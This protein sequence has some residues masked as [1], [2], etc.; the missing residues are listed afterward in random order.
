MRAIWS[1]RV[2][3]DTLK[4]AV[5]LYPAVTKQKLALHSIHSTCHSPIKIE[6]RCPIHGTI[7]PHETSKGYEMERREYIVLEN[8]V[9]RRLQPQ[10]R[11][12]FR[13]QHFAS[14]SSFEPIDFR[15]SYY[16]LPR[17]SQQ[18]QYGIF[19]EALRNSGLYG[20]GKIFIKRSERMAVIW[21]KEQFLI[22][23]T[24]TC[25][26]ERPNLQS[27]SAKMLDLGVKKEDIQRT[28]NLI[29]R[30]RSFAKMPLRED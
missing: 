3:F 22:A 29:K 15:R 8:E 11:R 26:N 12:V 6:R 30:H 24:L 21:A 2:C 18:R 20:V 19:R 10:S 27:L 14:P 1:G 23:S 7:S 9:L 16:M 25:D 13:I 28:E 4:I 17:P 5:K